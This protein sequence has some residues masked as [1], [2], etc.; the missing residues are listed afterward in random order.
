MS[1]P[2]KPTGDPVKPTGDPVKPSRET[3]P[4]RVVNAIRALSVEPVAFLFMFSLNISATIVQNL[5][6]EKACRYRLDF[7]EDVC[8]RLHEDE[9]ENEQDEVQKVTADYNMYRN[10]VEHVVPFFFTLFL[11]PWSD[12]NGRKIPLILVSV[13]QLLQMAGYFLNA[14]FMDWDIDWILVL[15]SLPYSMGGSVMCLIMSMFSYMADITETRSRTMRLSFMD[16]FFFAGRPLGS[17]AGAYLFQYFGYSVVF[18]VAMGVS[19]LNILYSVK[20]L[21]NDTHEKG[22]IGEDGKG[23]PAR[24]FLSPKNISDAF[25]ALFRKRPFQQRTILLILVSTIFISMIP[26]FGEYSVDYLFVQKQFDWDEVSYS[27]HNAYYIVIATG[28]IFFLVPLLSMKFSA[29]D[30]LIGGVGVTL[31]AICR[32]GYAFARR[33]WHFYAC[34]NSFFLLPL[35]TVR[36]GVRSQESGELVISSGDFAHFDI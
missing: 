30:A 12:R 27:L 33:S 11:G 13:G 2:V 22:Q 24:P 20:V 15:G 21:R 26:I 32:L 14:Y 17:L 1:E 35:L 16:G 29:S 6:M 5:T 25:K 23:R 3:F 31:N 34:E 19:A 28:G 10:I 7:S 4:R 18:G 9:F 36:T 8:D